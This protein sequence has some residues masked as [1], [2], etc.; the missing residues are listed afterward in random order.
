VRL[1]TRTTRSVSRT[2]AGEQLLAQAGT[3]R[4]SRRVDQ[5][6]RTTVEARRPDPTLVSAACRQD[7]RGSEARTVCS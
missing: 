1:L 2:D 6:V 7:R 5:L 3:V 4:H